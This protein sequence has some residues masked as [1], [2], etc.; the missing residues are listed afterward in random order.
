MDVVTQSVDLVTI[1]PH[2]WR[3]KRLTKHGSSILDTSYDTEPE[4]DSE[5]DFEIRGSDLA[6]AHWIQMHKVNKQTA[7]IEQT[8]LELLKSYR[9]LRPV[10]PFGRRIDPEDESWEEHLSQDIYF[11]NHCGAIQAAFTMLMEHKDEPGCVSRLLNEIGAHHFYYDATESHFECFQVAFMA[12]LKKKCTGSCRLDD[13][14]ESSWKTFLGE[15][16]VKISEGIAIQRVNYL[17]IAVTSSEIAEV[18]QQWH[19]ITE[20]G[21][22]KAGL[23]LCKEAMLNYKALLHQ[24][25]LENQ[26]AD[27]DK[28]EETLHQFVKMTMAAFQTSVSCWTTNDGFMGLPALL[29]EYVMQCM[30]LDVCPTL[31]RKAVQHGLVK[32][33]KKIL[34][35]DEVSEQ[36]E[37]MWKKMY[38]VVEQVN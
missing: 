28:D 5:V 15:V 26:I 18:R 11:K 7:V 8:F 10:W 16:K 34:G 14:I 1:N 19:T 2:P 37:Q 3:L 13:E 12:A 35:G 25:G 27:V 30:L 33:L 32:M 31:L 4:S 36:I 9:H 22:E 6:R 24:Y 23:V 17:R 38:R 20:Y 29:K 21:V